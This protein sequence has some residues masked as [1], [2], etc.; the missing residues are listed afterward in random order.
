MYLIKKLVSLIKR[1]YTYFY[2]IIRYI[3][4]EN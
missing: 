4:V 3:Y 1:M 2:I